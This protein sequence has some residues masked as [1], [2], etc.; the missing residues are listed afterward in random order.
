MER[1]S[2]GQ[3]HCNCTAIA[4]L[5]PTP[6][7]QGRKLWRFWPPSTPADRIYAVG[8]SG[9][10]PGW[11]SEANSFFDEDLQYDAQRHSRLGRIE[12]T[13]MEVI[14][15]PG[16]VVVIPSGWWHQVCADHSSN[17]YHIWT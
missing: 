4:L 7:L 10:V 8:D 15:E 5:T 6:T 1:F 9:T 16:E 17:Y 2:A 11:S 13:T 3:S 12:E 14:Q